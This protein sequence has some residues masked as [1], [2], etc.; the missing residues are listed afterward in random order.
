MAEVVGK[1]DKVLKELE[2]EKDTRQVQMKELA[3]RQDTIR[4]S[5]LD[6]TREIREI[7]DN[8]TRHVSEIEVSVQTLSERIE[9]EV[10]SLRVGIH[11]MR[12]ELHA[13]ISSREDSCSVI[14]STLDTERK[15]RVEV[16][17]KNFQLHEDL[18]IRMERA[19][20]AMLHDERVTREDAFT[21]LDQ[22]MSSLTQELNFEKA[23]IAAQGRDLSQSIT[24]LKDAI[25]SESNA[26]RD[27]LD[28]ALKSF[29]QVVGEV[30]KGSDRST[31]EQLLL[32]VSSLQASLKE[33]ASTRE[34]GL[35][36]CHDE[37]T[38]ARSLLSKEAAC[39]EEMEAK[40]LR[41][42]DEERSTV[43]ESLLKL[44][45]AA[46]TAEVSGL[47]LPKVRAM[48]DEE[49][50][51]RQQGL[52]QLEALLQKNEGFLAEERSCG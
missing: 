44:Q 37:L 25:L 2:N 3:S 34:L 10:K 7:E 45:T 49:C 51:G 17:D 46:T 21:L 24:Q 52:Q 6:G 8:Q 14:R 39:R 12:Q 22:R 4:N 29:E 11:E 32:S 23:K 38:E 1:L 27:E 20:R 5:F 36:I 35:Q 28:A 13:E 31:E 19:L 16:T 26:R 42:L 50:Q 15:T 30:Q 41:R 43:E 18:E 48:I 33:E 40:L 9:Q 47:T